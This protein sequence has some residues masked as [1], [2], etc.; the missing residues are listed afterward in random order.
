[1]ADC[2]WRWRDATGWWGWRR[3]CQV[4][5][6]PAPMKLW[7][8][9][10]CKYGWWWLWW[11]L[12]CNRWFNPPPPVNLLGSKIFSTLKLIIGFGM[13]S[14]AAAVAAGQVDDDSIVTSISKGV[15]TKTDVVT[16]SNRSISHPRRGERLLPLV[17]ISLAV[18]FKCLWKKTKQEREE[19]RKKAAWE[20][21]PL[22]SLV[23]FLCVSVSGFLIIHNDGVEG[24]P[25]W[26]IFFF[27]FESRWMRTNLLL[28]PGY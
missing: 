3:C 5:G 20:D 9:N 4:A 1:M 14:T 26:L 17:A 24:G 7:A 23:V 25:Y 18:V 8:W 10:W 13:C 19:K 11:W 21:G 6:W 28:Y 12:W 15:N 22:A 2:W 27:S 16:A